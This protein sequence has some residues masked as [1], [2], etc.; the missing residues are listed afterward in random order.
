[1]TIRC[2]YIIVL[3]L[4]KNNN[5]NLTKQIVFILMICFHKFPVVSLALFRVVRI[6]SNARSL[7]KSWIFSICF[8]KILYVEHVVIFVIFLSLCFGFQ[9]VCFELQ[10][11]TIK[12]F[13]YGFQRFPR[14][15]Y[16]VRCRDVSGFQ[17]RFYETTSSI[18]ILGLAVVKRY[19]Y[20]RTVLHYRR[21]GGRTITQNLG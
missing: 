7:E 5:N 3:L 4:K 19:R 20:V 12:C 15:F 1:M 18:R 9:N 21:R 6:T 2:Y 11:I 17:N 14:P 13:S 16:I 8:L 10:N